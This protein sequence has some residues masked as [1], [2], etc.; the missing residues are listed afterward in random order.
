MKGI[1]YIGD[2]A[3]HAEY[4]RSPG[5]KQEAKILS[6]LEQY[7]QDLCSFFIRLIYDRPLEI[8]VSKPHS[9]DEDPDLSFLG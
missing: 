2:I 3:D 7:F 4:R 6:F 1:G 8:S 5:Y 9:L